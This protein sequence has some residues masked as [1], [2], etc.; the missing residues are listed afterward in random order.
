MKNRIQKLLP[1][2]L[3]VMMTAT[4]FVVPA[5]AATASLAA[6]K[7]NT[8]YD[9]VLTVFTGA[10]E[11][12]I[13]SVLSGLYTLAAT[14]DSGNVTPVNWAD[15]TVAMDTTAAAA[16]QSCTIT[17]DG[18]TASIEGIK[19]SDK[20]RPPIVYGLWIEGTPVVGQELELH[21]AL[22]D[23][24]NVLG[25]TEEAKKTAIDNLVVWHRVPN[26]FGVNYA[27][28]DGAAFAV[29]GKN[30]GVKYTVQADDAGKYID[31][32]IA[33]PGMDVLS[34]AGWDRKTVTIG[35]ILA[36]KATAPSVNTVTISSVAQNGG[37]GIG[38][39]I[40]QTLRG[41]YY[42]VGA[43]AEGESVYQWSVS[44]NETTGFTPIEGA[45]QR[46]YTVKEADRG[47]YLKF[48]VTPKDEAGETGTAA[49]S[50]NRPKAGNAAYLAMATE[51][52]LTDKANNALQSG[53]N[54]QVLTNGISNGAVGD[55]GAIYLF[56]HDYHV[57]TTTIDLGKLQTITGVQLA[58]NKEGNAANTVDFYTSQDGLYWY[59]AQTTESA[60]PLLKD[61]LTKTVPLGKAVTFQSPVEGRYVQIRFTR[62]GGPYIAE[63]QAFVQET[64]PAPTL[65]AA[66]KD[67]VT[68]EVEKDATAAEVQKYLAENVT[69]TAAYD[70]GDPVTVPADAV[71]YTLDTSTAGDAVT[72]T[73]S[74]RGAQTT[75]SVKVK[76]AQL[77][78]ITV[79][80]AQGVS[81]IRVPLNT[82]AAG[83]KDLLADKIVITATY[84]GGSTE[85]ID[86]ADAE[87]SAITSAAGTVN[88]TV[89]YGGQSATVE[90]IVEEKEL[91]GI[92]VDKAEGVGVIGVLK[93]TDAEGLKTALADKIVITAS[94]S[95]GSTETVANADAA[96][97]ADTSATGA[98]DVTVSYGGKTATVS[99]NV[100]T[101]VTLTGITVEKAQ[102]V[103]D[104]K[105]SQGTDAAG[106]KTALADKIVITASYSDGSE[107]TIANAE[108]TYAADTT[109]IG[110]A[111]VTVTYEGKTAE[112]AVT[113]TKPEVA[114]TVKPS[115]FGMRITGSPVVGETLTFEYDLFDPNHAE[116]N[117]V[118]KIDW[119]Q[120]DTPEV[121][122]SPGNKTETRLQQGSATYTI[123]SNLVGKYIAVKV[124]ME[125]AS[126]NPR[127]KTMAVG[128]VLAAAPAVPTASSVTIISAPNSNKA[129]CDS[130]QTMMGDYLYA[131]AQAEGESTYQWYSASNP[132]GPFTAIEGA[133]KRT[134]TPTSN[135]WKKYLQFR[136]TPKDSAGT[137][138][139]EA[140]SYNLPRVGNVAYRAYVGGNPMQS[141]GT[142]AASYSGASLTALTNGA[143]T[144]AGGGITTYNERTAFPHMSTIIIDLGTVRTLEGARVYGS[145]TNGKDGV[146]LRISMTGDAFTPIHTEA[147]EGSGD[148]I[149]TYG[150]YSKDVAF[151]APVTG[152]YVEVGFTRDTNIR[153][154][155]IELFSVADKSPVITLKGD[156]EMK[157]LRGETYVEPGYTAI[158]E[159]DG[160]L[161]KQVRVV[162]TVDS[163]TVGTYEITYSVTDS[164]PQTI[165]AVRR[166][167]VS[168]GYHADGDL[169]YE[170]TVAADG[171]NAAL[172]VDGNKFTY[173]QAGSTT[174]SAVIDLG[175]EQKVSNAV[176]IENGNAVTGYVIEVS[177]DGN[178]WKTAHT[179]AAIGAQQSVD[180]EPVSGRYVRLRFTGASAAPKMAT[181]EIRFDDLGRA[182]EALAAI[183]LGGNLNAVT[184][185]LALPTKGLHG[186]VITWESDNKAAVSDTGI[187]HRGSTD[188]NAVLTATVTVG[189]TSLQKEFPPITVLKSTGGNNGNTGGSGGGIG[190][191]RNDKT[192]TIQVP[193][194]QM[195]VI[196]PVTPPV[197]E[198]SGLFKDV[199]DEYWAKEYIE[200]LGEK[201]IV[202]GKQDGVFDAE[203]AVTR[204][205]FL[206]MIVEIFGLQTETPAAAFTDVQENDWYY[207]YVA[208]AAALGVAQGMGDGSFGAGAP[209]SR[210]DMAVLVARAAKIADKNIGEAGNLNQ[211]TDAED[212][213]E[214][215]YKAMS[216]LAEA[217]I[218]SG[219]DKSA[220]NPAND[221]T[222]AEAAKILC[223][224]LKKVQ[225]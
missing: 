208:T 145:G 117:I 128:P 121:A 73:V 58:V 13:R 156:A 135:E 198:P 97:S 38:A 37:H 159:E 146:A 165:T 192:S 36:E 147:F 33:L 25:A 115:L 78:S 196:T 112:I 175:S 72:A 126:G 190:G 31:A 50:V 75:V 110:T 107:K 181:F 70:G 201:G 23:P 161:T 100:Q 77:Q 169:A 134:F 124:R 217:G 76:A 17:Y 144:D 188:Q 93:N 155:E 35:P 127:V 213:A 102:G 151:A 9:K 139:E 220:L 63:L 21:Y 26:A 14:D 211:F 18:A 153:L 98:A 47:K 108:A 149:V 69:V 74:A 81:D 53:A 140:A 86:G 160:D 141:N 59:P 111:L 168:E 191:G 222:R 34:K 202:N 183:T 2:M 84:E 136:V 101:V 65:A 5:S 187:V 119:L 67:G 125:G 27:S 195:P 207:T 40:G 19:I 104:I 71:T 114:K 90:V 8:A 116:S 200:S 113:V 170:K 92:T 15:A 167:I 179:G 66:A 174:S 7:K 44:E 12:E 212:V 6:T 88:V 10:T 173:W 99:V 223:L 39:N 154:Q 122:N 218:I 55:G 177:T 60:Q 48:T 203:G 29:Q 3:A 178:T 219:D 22:D 171:E 64:A 24:D 214:Y 16:A 182:K 210:Q 79:E 94:Y 157:L 199:A 184:E 133:T 89:S 131:G 4:L 85:T 225:A 204:A 193:A 163:D 106:L 95:D 41:E 152:R 87:Y 172:L 132:N 148:E 162:G 105:V 43:G 80:K 91:T 56:R 54:M 164:R 197:I 142:S 82:N 51:A 96:Y 46:E 61:F 130:A 20:K 30:N 209:I 32:A 11:D 83:L 206:K 138:G 45:T 150:T 186:A 129:G 42:Y 189:E 49:D 224:V 158:D 120:Q 215:A 52:G 68:L 103:S 176:L 166:V 123:P 137:A 180:F 1:L 109:Q 143:Y 62:V 216:Q 28:Y 205:E 221:A 57:D 118:S 194:V 185:D